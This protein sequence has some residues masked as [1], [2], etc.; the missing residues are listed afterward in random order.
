MIYEYPLEKWTDVGGSK[1]RAADFVI[2][3]RD[4]FRIYRKYLVG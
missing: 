3:L 1:V 4:V 2:A